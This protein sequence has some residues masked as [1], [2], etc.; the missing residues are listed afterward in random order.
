M[1]CGLKSAMGRFIDSSVALDCMM[2]MYT[3][4]P[5]I[6]H[7]AH[8]SMLMLLYMMQFAL[9]PLPS[10][11]MQVASKTCRITHPTTHGLG[12][13]PVLT[14]ASRYIGPHVPIYQYNMQLWGYNGRRVA[15]GAAE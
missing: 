2:L 9:Y 3:H 12:P 5:V 11:V 1:A 7:Q 15:T 10:T 6:S 4:C 14:I 8:S 13:G